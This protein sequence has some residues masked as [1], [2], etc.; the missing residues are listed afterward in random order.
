MLLGV[1]TVTTIHEMVLQ[2]VRGN[3]LHE[4]YSSF[5][6][7]PVFKKASQQLIVVGL[8]KIQT[9]AIIPDSGNGAIPLTATF[10]IS[11]LSDFKHPLK[12][13]EDFFFQT[14]FPRMA[15]IGGVLCE[16][17]PASA[18]AKLQKTIFSGLFCVRGFYFEEATE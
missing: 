8:E 2:A 13:S 1:A 9:E 16:V 14:I 5:D 17:L 12:N 10:R 6:G 7:V 3:D 11:V 18:D 15:S 4:V